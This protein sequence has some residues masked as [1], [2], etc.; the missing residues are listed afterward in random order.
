MTK[1]TSKT[2]T[3]TRCRDEQDARQFRII[4][5]YQATG[6]PRRHPWCRTCEKL[7]NDERRAR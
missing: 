5:S 6:K 7:S 2:K 1:V 3:C 4:G